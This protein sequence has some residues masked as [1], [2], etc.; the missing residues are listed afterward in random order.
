MKYC[1]RELTKQEKTEWEPKLSTLDKRILRISEY[2]ASIS[3]IV[4]KSK[5]FVNEKGSTERYTGFK[6]GSSVS[7][8]LS[9]GLLERK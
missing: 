3:L 4:A 2:G 6:V 7:S 9:R 1:A 5:H 8:L